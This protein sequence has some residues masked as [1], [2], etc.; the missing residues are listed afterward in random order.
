M[1]RISQ[2]A[3]WAR[4]WPL[5]NADG[6]PITDWS[7]WAALA[8]VRETIDAAQ[9]VWS[10]QTT[11]DDDAFAGMAE[12]GDGGLTLSHKAADTLSWT[13]RLGVWDLRV[14]NPSDQVALADR[15]RV[16]VIPVVT[17]T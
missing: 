2:G 8:Q 4:F 9:P 14:T 13:W 17:R 1:M 7:G 3:D 16:M 6:T 12:F 11:P 15:G 5:A 10:W